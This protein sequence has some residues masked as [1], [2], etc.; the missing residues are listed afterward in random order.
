MSTKKEQAFKKVLSYAVPKSPAPD[1]TAAVMQEVTANFKDE[2][3]VNPGLKELIQLHG[4][5]KA[6][7]DFSNVVMG[8]LQ[9]IENPA[10]YHPIISKK[11]GFAIA[12]A[13]VAVILLLLLHDGQH[14]YPTQNN[15]YFQIPALLNHIPSI[16]ILTLFMLCALLLGDYFLRQHYPA[17]KHEVR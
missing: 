1:F 2:A 5:E 10:V 11:A 14:T 16:Y 6:P 15:I 7:A 12:A 13:M 4:M 9:G 8:R 3:V 17:T